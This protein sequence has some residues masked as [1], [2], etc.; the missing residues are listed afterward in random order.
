MLIIYRISNSLST[1]E[2]HSVRYIE[3]VQR[4]AE[5]TLGPGNCSL[6]LPQMA[7]ILPGLLRKIQSSRQF[8][9]EFAAV[10]PETEGQTPDRGAV[11]TGRVYGIHFK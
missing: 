10:P 2:K 6:I 8:F 5:E 3:T 1:H 4:Y 11:N 9:Y 7:S